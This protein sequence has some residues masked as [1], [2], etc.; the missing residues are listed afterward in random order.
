M[1]SLGLDDIFLGRQF[2]VLEAASSTLKMKKEG[3]R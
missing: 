2:L 1:I 3:K